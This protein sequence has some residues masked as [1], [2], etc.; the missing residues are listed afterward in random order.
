MADT[1][2]IRP[3]VHLRV[4]STFSLGVG[5][6]TPAEV[7]AHAHRV[8]YRAVALTDING[9]YGYIEFHHAAR[10]LGIK[11]I[12]GTMVVVDW[13]VGDE[14]PPDERHTLTLL[15]LDRPGLR[16]VCAAASASASRREEDV[17]F[18][19]SDLDDLSDG[20]VCIVG[21]PSTV[22]AVLPR[23]TRSVLTSLQTTFGDRLF[24]ETLTHVPLEQE[25]SRHQLDALAESLGVPAVLCQDVRFV[26]PEKQRL[27]DLVGAGEGGG[28]SESR[29]PTHQHGLGS[30]AEMSSF[31]DTH[32][33]AYTNASLIASLV[34]PDIL[35]ALGTSDRTLKSLP[36]FADK[37]DIHQAFVERVQAQF[38]KEFGGTTGGERERWEA[39]L[40]EEMEIIHGT[41]LED[42]FLQFREIANRVQRS[43]RLMG[44]AT[45]LRLQSLCAYL[46]GIT[47]FNPYRIDG[48]FRPFFDERDRVNR[49]FDLQV[50]PGARRATVLALESLFDAAGIGFVPS[51]EHITAARSLRMA[52]RRLTVKPPEYDDILRVATQNP[53]ATLQDLC[54]QNRRI[55]QI[56]KRSAVVRDL[57][58]HAAPLEGLPFGF[59][60]SKRTLI[61][62]PTP[63]REFLGETVHAKTGDVFVQSTRD[64]FPIGS[65]SRV[66]LNTLNAL[67]VCARMGVMDDKQ[68]ITW[69]EG[70]RHQDIYRCIRNA[71]VDGV[72]LLETPLIQRLAQAFEIG[73]FDDLLRFLALMRY[74]RGGFSLADRVEAYRKGDRTPEDE[75]G[76]I[77]RFT[78]GWIL[79]HD[80][81]RDIVTSVTGLDPLNAAQMV[82][83]FARQE[84]GELASLRREFMTFAVEWGTPM[85]AATAWFGR[86]LH[87]AGSTVWRQ[88]VLADALIVS[89]MLYLKERQ[90][91]SFLVALVNVH[92]RSDARRNAY[93]ERLSSQTD[94][95]SPDINASAAEFA[96][97]GGRVRSP[98]WMIDGVEEEDA[99]RIVSARGSKKVTGRDE[100]DLLSADA[101]ISYETVEALVRA[102]ALESAGISPGDVVSGRAASSAASGTPV[103]NASARETAQMAFA[104][105]SGGEQSSPDDPGGP[106]PEK[107]VRVENVGNKRVVFRVLRSLTEFHPH[108]IA[109]PVEMVGRIRDLRT[110]KSSTGETVG[111]FMLFD[112]GASVPVF[113]PWERVDPSCGSLADGDTVL[114]RGRVRLREGMRACEALEVTAGGGMND[115]ETT[116]DGSTTGDP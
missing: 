61:I 18:V 38:E 28:A 73:S 30:P 70:S 94:V 96:V 95:L 98:L 66:D 40:R 110:F 16:N 27:V 71:D 112:S 88:Q 5:L 116:P 62:S 1:S 76:K 103:E 35:G 92:R 59:I 20:V 34:Q 78:N 58:S 25:E 19:V 97:E 56:Y 114:V 32:Q 67:E 72:Y 31:F 100:F 51:V 26:G 11:P 93:L 55:G 109:S 84:P 101:G 21:L 83:R 50:P 4:H 105:A 7:C 10:S 52:A 29:A 86:V 14:T 81:L 47:R 63:L 91:I 39:R 37:E 106:P 48:H 6:S 65:I 64:S 44:P 42:T 108:P 3:F 24:V 53:G 80:Q 17:P 8:G 89:T 85:E 68:T 115:G 12:Y 36:M 79:F 41:E 87:A 99:R 33:E 74:R 69:E 111:F 2:N 13:P 46:L 90:P 9:T 104:L 60:R 43:V 23:S 102:G 54:T 22:T 82:R 107:V 49:V 15:A 75:V 57:I 77:L 113:V 45:G